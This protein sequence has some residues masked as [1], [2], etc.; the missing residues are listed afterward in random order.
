MFKRI[1]ALNSDH[2]PVLGR[3]VPC[4]GFLVLYILWVKPNVKIF[5]SL[6]ILNHWKIMNRLWL[7]YHSFKVWTRFGRDDML[8]DL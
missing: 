1:A 3:L 8:V 4:L 2:G 7:Q 6:C 5:M